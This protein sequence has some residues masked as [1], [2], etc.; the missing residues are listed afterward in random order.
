[1]I[2]HYG[3]EDGLRVLS[4]GGIISAVLS[5]RNYGKTW[6][7]KKRAFKRALKRGK[8]TVWLRM[9]KKEAKECASTFFSSRDLREYCCIEFY[10]KEKNAGNVKQIGNVFYFRK[11][12]KSGKWTKWGWFLKVFALSDDDAIRS[13]DD[14]DVDTII[15]DEMTKTPSKYNRFRGNIVNNF[16]D[17]LFSSKREHSIR[18]VLL[19]NKESYNN[20][21]FTYFGIKPLPSSFEGIRAYRNGSFV[22]QQINNISE[23]QSEYDKKMRSLLEG[24][25]YGNYIYKSDYK[26]ASSFKRRKTPAGSSIYCQLVF[27]GQPIKISSHNGLFYINEKIDRSKRVYCDALS[28]KFPHELLLVKRQKRFFEAFVNAL[29]DNR[30]FYDSPVTYESALPFFQWLGI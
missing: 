20:P 10:D 15:F 27:N 26:E 21:F 9:F 22:V 2:K 7:F 29:S 12:T 8:K 4:Y 11:K 17:I 16:I 25:Q 1:M 13:A 23:E 30:V 24:T 3:D 14:V 5:N 28:G 19:G 18:C 6:T